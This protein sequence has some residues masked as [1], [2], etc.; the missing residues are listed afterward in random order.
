MLKTDSGTSMHGFERVDSVDSSPCLLALIS[1][2]K[3]QDCKDLVDKRYA[4]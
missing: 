2:P 1:L 4:P 3:P